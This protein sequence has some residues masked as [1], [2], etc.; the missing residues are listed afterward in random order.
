MASKRS[1]AGGGWLT[2]LDVLVVAVAAAAIVALFGAQTR[3]SLG[4]LRV[5]IRSPLNLSLA[6]A[7][8]VLLR[9]GVG[10]RRR[11]FPS[12]P[13]PDAARFAGDQARLARPAAWTRPAVLCAIAVALGSLV[14]IVPHLLHP[15]MVPDYGDPLFSAWRIARIA[16]QLAHDP[17]HLFDGNIFYPLPLTLTLS[18]ATFLQALLGTPF[19]LAGVDPL[20][21]ANAMTMIAFPLCGLAFYVTGWRLTGDPFAGLVA[22]LLGAWYPFHA[23]HYS[24]LELHWIMFAPL[25][26]L[27]GMRLLADPRPAN[28]LRFGAAVALQ[29]LA[30]MYLGVMLV[31]FL[32][33]FLSVVALAWRVRPSRQVLTAC[34]AAAAIAAP[35]FAGLGLPFMSARA[36]RGERAMQEVFDGS[37]T[38]ADYTHAHY[39]MLSYHW[40]GGRGHRVERELFPGSTTIVLAAAGAMPPLSTAGTAAIVAGAFAFDWSLGLNG[41]TYDEL[42]RLSSVYRGMRVMARFSAIVGVALVVLGAIGTARLLRRIGP[43]FR[44]FACAALALLVLLDLRMEPRLIGFPAGIPPIYSRVTPDMVLVELP[45]DPQIDYMYFST[46][47]WA[48]LVGGYSGFPKYTETLMDGWK[49]WPSPRAIDFFKRTGATHVT[50][51]CAL[52]ERPWRCATAFETLDTAPGLELLAS[53]LWQGKETRLYRFR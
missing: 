29:W 7:I 30:S 9:A 36:I 14:W 37:A 22:G 21:V 33:P 27:A 41:L 2:L 18:D 16:H 6:A 20:I 13:V 11:L 45:V 52:E 23:E 53:G 51:N 34:A 49:A 15:R 26:I 1:A 25:A 40:L 24:H 46:Q 44:P 47:H 32:V 4:G 35:A 3:F 12:L 28:G 38:G 42:Y 19:V 31:S 17:R 10:G 8:L 39:R 5:T 43:P 48:R 50:Y